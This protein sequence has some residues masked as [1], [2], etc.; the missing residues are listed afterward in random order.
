MNSYKDVSLYQIKHH[1]LNHNFLLEIFFL[2][3]IYLIVTIYEMTVFSIIF[4]TVTATHISIYKTKRTDLY[5][6]AFYHGYMT[7]NS[8]SP[9]WANLMM[10]ILRKIFL[11]Y[12]LSV[13]PLVF[14]IFWSTCNI[15]NIY[16]SQT[17]YSY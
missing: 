13:F 15:L 8:I 7:K 4:S 12:F 2:P 6:G 1:L 16:V 11:N 14:D 17:S 10:N 5:T 9:Q 3:K